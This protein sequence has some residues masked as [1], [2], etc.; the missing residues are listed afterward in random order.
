MQTLG[1]V[2]NKLSIILLSVFLL[3][4]CQPSDEVKEPVAEAEKTEANNDVVTDAAPEANDTGTHGENDG[5]GHNHD[6]AVKAGS[7]APFEEVTSDLACEAPIVIEFFAYQCP[8]CYN[9]ESAAEAWRKKTGSK[10][11]FLSVPT[12][13]GRNEFGSLLLVHHAAQK[14]GVLDK[15]RHAL[16]ER[17]HKEKKLF[18]NPE[19]AADF[20]AEQGADGVNKV[21]IWEQLMD[22]RTPVITSNTSTMYAYTWT[23]LAKDGPTVIEIPPGMLGFLDDAWQ[24]FVGLLKLDKKDIRQIFFY[25]I[26]AG[27]VSLSLPLVTTPPEA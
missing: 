6:L 5:H 21:A 26:F 4:A 23:N 7:G 14:L 20:L 22:S 15:A 18:A 12:H 16:F 11:E 10:V 17:V 8:H 3:A 1:V 27:L 24:R 13:L 9:L 2:V 19:E 25:A